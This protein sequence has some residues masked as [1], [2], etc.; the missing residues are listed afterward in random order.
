MQQKPKTRQQDE[1]VQKICV[2]NRAITSRDDDQRDENS[3]QDDAN[4]RLTASHHS[5]HVAAAHDLYRQPAEL[6]EKQT[7]VA[8]S[9]NEGIS[10]VVTIYLL[11]Q[12]HETMPP[13]ACKK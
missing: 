3:S 4:L 8:K 10:P 1:R 7:D 6:R 2:Y 5:Q 9:S 11:A 13:G 12:R